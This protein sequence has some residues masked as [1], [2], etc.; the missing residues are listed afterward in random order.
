MRISFLIK[1]IWKFIAIFMTVFI[2]SSLLF[3]HFEYVPEE[4]RD[5]SYAGPDDFVDS[6]WFGLVTMSTVGY[7]DRYP[8]TPEGKAAALALVIFT[9]TFLGAMIGM[10]S[11]AVLEARRREELGMDKT[12]FRKH[13][14]IC[15]WTG[16]SKVS[17][18]ELMAIG[19]KVVVITNNQDDIPQIRDLGDKKHLYIVF[20]EYD[21]AKVLERAAVA[22]AKTVIIVTGSDTES[23]VA[24]LTIKSL[25]PD[26]RLVVSIMKEELRKTLYTAGVTYVS[27]PSEMTGRLAASASF[28]PEVAHFVEDITSATFGYD[29]QQYTV[30]E[31]CFAKG[32][33]VS[34]F[35]DRMKKSGGPLLVGLGKYNPRKA[36]KDDSRGDYDIIPNPPQNTKINKNDI[37]IVLGN[38][39]END[40]LAQTLNVPQGR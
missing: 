20:G 39:D 26:V 10:V 17:L 12:K 31:E 11:D 34:Q 36:S 21:N 40:K 16:I 29:L 4:E 9:F 28:E 32:M 6:F 24:S 14:V 37:L 25:A 13:I 33:T 8:A 23:L 22:K 30:N 27:T 15:G 3:Y 19:E 7:G 2:V 1:K 35:Q 38:D 18:E 5:D